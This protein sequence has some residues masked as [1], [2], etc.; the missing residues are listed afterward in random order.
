MKLHCSVIDFEVGG[1]GLIFQYL[2]FDNMNHISKNTTII[3]KTFFFVF[4]EMRR[5]KMLKEALFWLSKAS[6]LTTYLLKSYTLSVIA[7]KTLSLYKM[8]G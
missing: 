3:W 2:K 6:F 7:N 4:A 5:C 1:T 8:N